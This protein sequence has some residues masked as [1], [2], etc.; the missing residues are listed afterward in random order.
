M[1]RS[2]LKFGQLIIT[3]DIS[4]VPGAFGFSHLLVNL[5]HFA[6]FHKK[7]N[8]YSHKK[9]TG[10]AFIWCCTLGVKFLSFSLDSVCNQIQL[11]S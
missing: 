4:A 3:L 7:Q 2:N 8:G 11:Q 9:R 6:R 10:I 1:F 5:R